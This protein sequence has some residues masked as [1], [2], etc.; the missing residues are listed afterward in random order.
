MSQAEPRAR[1]ADSV[2]NHAR[3]MDAARTQIAAAGPE[4]GMTEIAACAGVAV[5]TL[6]RHFATK[7]DLVA[8]VIGEFVAQVADRAEAAK[9]SVAM[10]GHAFDELVSF[11]HYVLEASAS[12]HAVKAAARALGAQPE[13]IADEQRARTALTSVIDAA[14]DAGDVRDDLT[15]DDLYLVMNTAPTDQSAE[16]LNRW[17][18][19]ALYGLRGAGRGARTASAR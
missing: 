17:L 9:A 19:L 11:L 5:G 1:R 18:D 13:E 6:Y 14:R 3:I 7:T 10:G 15:V 8:A 16:R 12:N 2:R 4:V